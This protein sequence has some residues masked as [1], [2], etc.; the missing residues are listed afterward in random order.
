L[1]GQV[2]ASWVPNTCTIRMTIALRALGL[3]PGNS[4]HSVFNDKYKNWYLI[5][6]KNM[7]PYMDATF[8]KPFSTKTSPDSLVGEGM[9]ERV[10]VIMYSDCRFGDATGHFDIWDGAGLKDH[11][12][13]SKKCRKAE[14]WNVCNI[15]RNPDYSKLLLRKK[16]EE[17]IRMR[18]MESFNKKLRASQGGRAVAVVHDV[19]EF[20]P[21]KAQIIQTQEF[22]KKVADLTNDARYV[23]GSKAGELDQKTLKAIKYFRAKHEKSG[24][25]ASTF[26]SKKTYELIIN[27]SSGDLSE[28]LKEFIRCP[29]KDTFWANGKCSADSFFGGTKEVLDECC[30]CPEDH[31]LH[32]R[33]MTSSETEPKCYFHQKLFL[34]KVQVS[35]EMCCRDM[36]AQK[37]LTE[38]EFNRIKLNCPTAKELHMRP[39]K[40]RQRTKVCYFHKDG[41][42]DAKV[43]VDDFCCEDSKI[44]AG[45]YLNERKW[46]KYVRSMQEAE[47]QNT[48]P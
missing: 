22:L 29:N 48:K 35:A 1:G 32:Y 42:Y 30:K 44:K 23:P 38:S 17:S 25:R 28:S 41:K 18:H 12:Y 13:T 37:Y 5:R 9:G 19:K 16:R 24:D 40:R 20:L 36:A 11:G 33:P 21:T 10:G 39:L 34:E 43:V 31:T 2:G 15:K 3:D 4:G 6:V 8:G 46:R 14:I 47:A 7:K 45:K 26:I 27:L